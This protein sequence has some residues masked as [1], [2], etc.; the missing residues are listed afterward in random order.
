MKINFFIVSFLLFLVGCDDNPRPPKEK[1]Y[2][3]DLVLL[4]IGVKASIH[5]KAYKNS[6]SQPQAPSVWVYKVNVG[7]EAGASQ[8][9][10]RENEIE[11]CLKESPTRP[12]AEISQ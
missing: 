2:R 7:G 1:Y 4:T 10:V 12:K 8:I 9:E 5:D 11:K 6:T 3:G